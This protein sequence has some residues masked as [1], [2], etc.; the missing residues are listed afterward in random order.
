[1]A[2][3][4][5]VSKNKHFPPAFLTDEHGKAMHSWRILILPYI[6]QN[7]LYKE[8]S[9]KEPWDGPNNRKLAARMP[10]VFALHGE[11]YLGNTTTNYLAVVGPATIWQGSKGVPVDAVSDGLSQTI[12][13]VENK[14]AQ[15]HWMEPRD[16]SF[17]QMDYTLNSPRGISSRY[18][19]PAVTMADGS[20]YRLTCKVEPA[21][22][23]A[24]LTINGGEKMESGGESGWQLLPH[25]RQRHEAQP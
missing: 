2:V 24:M 6:E 10:P 21:T 22:L 17:A 5:Y 3:A 19:D 9:F 13:I 14:G 20:V 1:L 18:L 12:L 7:E 4:N 11:E 15:I 23:R 25:G 8:Y 16:L